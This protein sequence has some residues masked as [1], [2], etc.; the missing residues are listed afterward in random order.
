MDH[1]VKKP[2]VV[3]RLTNQLHE[4]NDRNQLSND[5]GS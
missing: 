1:Q 4:E 2:A 3:E 5:A